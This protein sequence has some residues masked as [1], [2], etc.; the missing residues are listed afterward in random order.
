[1]SRGFKVGIGALPL[2]LFV[3]SQFL[4]D[5]ARKSA[6][7]D[8]PA[9]KNT[10]PSESAPLKKNASLPSSKAQAFRQPSS[11]SDSKDR[12]SPELR[13]RLEDVVRHQVPMQMRD[14][15]RF[16]ITEED[17]TI[18]KTSLTIDDIKIEGSDL[19]FVRNEKTGTLGPATTP[20]PFLKGTAAGFPDPTPD[21]QTAIEAELASLHASEVAV[22]PTQKIWGIDKKGYLIPMIE[23]DV[24]YRGDGAN[25]IHETWRFNADKGILAN[26]RSPVRN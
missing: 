12:F 6:L 10:L 8:V 17:P 3:A 24:Q 4:S 15:V 23:Y 22:V 9:A 7:P 18:V 16:A 20:L 13:A 11:L 1:M 2:V 19:R 5:P 14:K 21:F 26:R 25:A